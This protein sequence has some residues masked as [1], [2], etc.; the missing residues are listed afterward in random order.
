M[1]LLF[2]TSVVYTDSNLKAS[3]VDTA[4]NLPPVSA[5]TVENL[6]LVSTTSALSAAKFAA[7]IIDTDSKLATSIKNTTGT[8]GWCC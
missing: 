2:A 1:F 7:G 3:D 8:A 5:I 4:G 6:P